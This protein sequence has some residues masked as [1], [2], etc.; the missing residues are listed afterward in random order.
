MDDLGGYGLKDWDNAAM[1]HLLKARL[2]L[3][4]SW[5]LCSFASLQTPHSP[6]TTV[7]VTRETYLPQI[8]RHG[9]VPTGCSP[10]RRPQ[11]WQTRVPRFE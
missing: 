9:E 10:T 11:A 2:S 1:R 7:P 5:V 3:V 6:L 8:A 4:V